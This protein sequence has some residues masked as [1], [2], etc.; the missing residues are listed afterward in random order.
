MQGRGLDYGIF[1]FPNAAFELD[2]VELFENEVMPHL[3]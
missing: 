1:Y 2:A 3:A